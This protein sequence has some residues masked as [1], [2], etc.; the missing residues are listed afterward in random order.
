MID[1]AW[2]LYWSAVKRRE[3]ARA[4]GFWSG[5]DLAPRQRRLEA[6]TLRAIDRFRKR[7]DGRRTPD[8]VIIGMPKSATSWLR[9]MLDQHPGI[10]TVRGELEF[11]AQ[12]LEMGLDRYL[13]HFE[14]VASRPGSGERDRLL[15]GE[16]SASTA[17]MDV[18]RIRMMQ[19]LMPDA[20]LVILLRDPVE[21]HWAHAKR[22]FSKKRFGKRGFD[23]SAV[24]RTDFDAFFAAAKRFGEYSAILKRWWSVFGRESL[25]VLFQEDIASD[26]DA[27][28][29]RTIA[30]VGGEP[31]LF[32]EEGLPHRAVR[33]RGPELAMPADVEAQLMEM[34][35]GEYSKLESMIGPLPPSWRRPDAV[36]H[37]AV[38]PTQRRT[39]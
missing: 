20:R 4:T 37:G 24:D 23:L 27:A 10:V 9:A 13:A 30:H 18:D 36:R 22:F 32:P 6:A 34:F 8:F 12:R 28:L 1:G 39:G 35:A 29:L 11:F 33:N 25:L 2:R 31:A 15:I 21:R 7:G 5:L 16:K 38:P 14:N 17:A 26:P 3:L 19:R